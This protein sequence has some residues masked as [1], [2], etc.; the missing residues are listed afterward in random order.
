MASTSIKNDK[1]TGGVVGTYS[2]I[3][4]GG[5]PTIP[6]YIDLNNLMMQYK[7]YLTRKDATL[8]NKPMKYFLTRVIID[9]SQEPFN[10]NLNSNVEY[11]Y[12]FKNA[13]YFWHAAIAI[14]LMVEGQ[15]YDVNDETKLYDQVVQLEKQPNSYNTIKYIIDELK[16]YQN[17]PKFNVHIA[18]RKN[19]L[20]K[21][22][23]D[24]EHYLVGT[25]DYLLH[26]LS[27][28]DAENKKNPIICSCDY[29][30]D[31]NDFNK[32]DPF[33]YIK[34]DQTLNIQAV[35][36]KDPKTSD[37]KKWTMRKEDFKIL[38]NGF[39]CEY[40]D[41]RNKPLSATLKI[42]R[43]PNNGNVNSL[44]GQHNKL[45]IRV[46]PPNS[47]VSPPTMRLNRSP[48]TAPVA[49]TQSPLPYILTA[50]SAS[51]ASPKP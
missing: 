15:N 11:N 18:Y 43:N 2:N 35:G 24:N 39:E 23:S 13:D 29:F 20:K 28:H 51:A 9:Y 8:S 12:V 10:K 46:V 38:N 50:S 34:F 45:T 22:P 27:F 14:G 1:I 40:V 19:Y 30:K 42:Q 36:L 49:G 32:I 5:N 44:L 16:Q 26:D 6:V 37:P 33:E 47:R 17:L 25:D 21:K 48:Q 4:T 31:K 41:R 3:Y 7:D